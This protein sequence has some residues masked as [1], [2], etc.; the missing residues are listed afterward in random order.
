MSKKEYPPMP[1]Y[2]HFRSAI[3]H[4]KVFEEQLFEN[5]AQI[6]PNKD[7]SADIYDFATGKHIARYKK[8]ETQ[9]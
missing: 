7:G 6:V 8:E 9:K 3:N 1:R 2:E 4:D 5:C